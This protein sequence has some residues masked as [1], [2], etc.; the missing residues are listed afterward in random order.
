MGWLYLFLWVTR[1][2]SYFARLS[3]T[4]PETLNGPELSLENYKCF[5]VWS[6]I[7]QTIWKM[8][9]KNS[10]KTPKIPKRRIGIIKKN[11]EN[12]NESTNLDYMDR[13]ERN[14]STQLFLEFVNNSLRPIWGFFFFNGPF[15]DSFTDT[16]MFWRVFFG[17][18]KMI[19]WYF[20]TFSLLSLLILNSYQIYDWNIS[21]KSIST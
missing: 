16:S 18:F 4:F 1:L 14:F 3:E 19:I 15:R 7:F 13:W 9:H 2:L 11:S 20:Q 8:F 17:N 6:L 21:V 12:P 10:I 5:E